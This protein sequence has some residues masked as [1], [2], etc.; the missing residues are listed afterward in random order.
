MLVVVEA[1]VIDILIDK[2]FEK[3][4]GASV[5]ENKEKS[6]LGEVVEEEEEEEQGDSLDHV[7]QVHL[8]SI[9]NI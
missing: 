3:S 6:P 8:Q 5:Q 7:V 1:T 4:E 9:K 2:M